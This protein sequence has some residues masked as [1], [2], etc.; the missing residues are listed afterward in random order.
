MKTFT[1]DSLERYNRFSEYRNI[2]KS[3]CNKPWVA[4]SE[5]VEGETYT[6][7]GN[8]VVMIALNGNT[9]KGSWQ[10]DTKTSVLSL[11]GSNSCHRFA[12]AFFDRV[13]LAL[14]PQG[15]NHNQQYS[16]LVNKSNDKFFEPRHYTDIVAYLRSKE[17]DEDRQASIL[18][19]GGDVAS[20]SVNDALKQKVEQI[21][22]ANELQSQAIELKQQLNRR[23][24]HYGW[25]AVVGICTAVYAALFIFDYLKTGLPVSEAIINSL[26]YGTIINVPV[27]LLCINRLVAML[28]EFVN[29]KRWKHAHPND[30]RNRFL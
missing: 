21:K 11:T 28:L 25:L 7:M 26:F 3:I 16:F 10:I 6:F 5:D 2:K 17:Q 12:I 22:Q 29:I 4:F 14:Q 23:N 27:S 15:E 18:A 9:L 8:G 13:L 24:K 19:N 1:F 20:A 30:S